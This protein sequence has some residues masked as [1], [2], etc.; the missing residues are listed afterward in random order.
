[1]SDRPRV[2]PSRVVWAGEALG[3][4]ARV[5]VGSDACVAQIR[6]LDG[7]WTSPDA[8]LERAALGEAVISLSARGA[9]ACYLL[10]EKEVAVNDGTPEA[11]PL[12]DFMDKVWS[13]LLSEVDRA[14]L[15]ARGAVSAGAE[16]V[17]GNKE[18]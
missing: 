9:L 14:R 12:R 2:V 18:R 10:L 13:R 17:D 16:P 7:S 1:M 3:Y 8:V 15:N 11:E 5:V 4:A 6:A